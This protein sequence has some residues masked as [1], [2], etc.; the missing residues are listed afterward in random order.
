M[1]SKPHYLHLALEKAALLSVDYIQREFHCHPPLLVCYGWKIGNT[2]NYIIITLI[3]RPLF[4]LNV[5]LYSTC[6]CSTG[7]NADNKCMYNFSNHH[8]YVVGTGSLSLFIPGTVILRHTS[9]F[10]CA[11]I[12]IKYTRTHSKALLTLH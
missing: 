7:I 3:R 1:C 8:T 12:L 9:L 11:Y 10:E 6:I 2:R 5:S 4:M